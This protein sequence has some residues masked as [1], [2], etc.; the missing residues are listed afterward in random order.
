MGGCVVVPAG[1]ADNPRGGVVAD[2]VVGVGAVVVV[3][4][5]GTQRMLVVFVA[6][7]CP[8]MIVIPLTCEGDGVAAAGC[9]ALGVGD[10]VVLRV[11]PAV[12]PDCGTVPTGQVE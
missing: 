11:A 5:L 7:V 9:C 4:V 12:V 6:V 10:V 1:G 2:G 3:P 8:P